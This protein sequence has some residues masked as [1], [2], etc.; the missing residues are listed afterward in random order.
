MGHGLGAGL[1]PLGLCLCG[2]VRRGVALDPGA[3][4]RGFAAALSGMF[5]VHR[6]ARAGALD[7]GGAHYRRI[8]VVGRHAAPDGPNFCQW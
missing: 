7:R 2:W 8:R 3:I 1:D 6:V 4:Q 5:V